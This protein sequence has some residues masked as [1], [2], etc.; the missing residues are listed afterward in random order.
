MRPVV[1]VP[2]TRDICPDCGRSGCGVF[3]NVTAVRPHVLAHQAEHR[4]PSDWFDWSPIVTKPADPGPTKEE[5]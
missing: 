4:Y 2:M 3:R 5:K 1:N